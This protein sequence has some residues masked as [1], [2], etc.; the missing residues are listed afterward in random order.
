MSETPLHDELYD[1]CANHLVI[2]VSIAVNPRFLMELL[3]EPVRPTYIHGAEFWE[4]H[5]LPLR[6]DEKIE[7]FKI[8]RKDQ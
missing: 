8:A 7:R 1:A 4:F 2:P 5:G 3:N 6:P